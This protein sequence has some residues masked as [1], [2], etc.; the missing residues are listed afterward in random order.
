M[1]VA[2]KRVSWLIFVILAENPLTW[3]ESHGSFVGLRDIEI[4]ETWVGGKKLYSR[5]ENVAESVSKQLQKKLATAL[6]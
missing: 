4:E 6:T 1:W 5:T 2:W 3:N